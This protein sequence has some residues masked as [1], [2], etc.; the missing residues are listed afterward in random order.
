MDDAHAPAAAAMGRLEDHRPAELL[1]NLQGVGLAGD[2]LG[3]A[4]QDRHAGA[5][6][7]IAG[8]GLVA[9]R[10]Q[11]FDPGAD[12]S[13]ASLGAGRSECRVFGE[14]SIA[15]VDGIDAVGLGEG[16]NRPD[17]EIRADRFAGAAHQI[18]LV[19]LESME[20]EPVLMG[21]DRDRADPQFMRRAEDADG[22][23]AAVGDHQLGDRADH[24]AFPA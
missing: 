24:G 2:R 22:D 20:G 15:G 7:Q 9:E 11:Q 16:N 14:E 18:R 23:L 5:L 6:G 21:V 13:D 12:E 19:S 17:V 8:G 3:T 1:G 10:P 4:S